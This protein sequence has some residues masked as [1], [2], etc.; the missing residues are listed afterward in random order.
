MSTPNV[1]VVPLQGGVDQVTTPILVQPGKLLSSSNY[2]PDIFGGYARMRGIER[3]DGRQSPT[4]AP[5]YVLLGTLTET[6]NVGD[7]VTGNTS[8]ATGKVIYLDTASTPD[9]IVVTRVTGTFVA[10]DLLNG[11]TVGS[12]TSAVYQ[13][14]TTTEEHSLY[15]KLTAAEYRPDIQTVPGE[16]AVLGVWEYKNDIYAFRNNVGSTQ[17]RMY[18]ATVSGWSQI[19]FGKELQFDAA[20]GEI[21]EGQ[22]VTGLSSGATGVVQRA[23]L[24]TGTWTSAGVGTLF[25]DTIT[26]AFTDNEAVQVGGVT[27][28][29]ANGDS[30]SVTLA[31]SGKFDFDN[32][33]FFAS[34]DKLR[35]YFADGQNYCHEFDGTRIIP[36]RTGLVDDKP[37]YVKGHRNHLFLGIQSSLQYSGIGSPYSWTAL[38]GAAELG[39]G[40]NITGV[41]PQRGD[42]TTG[43]LLA[44]TENKTYILYGTSSADFKLVLYSD[45]N[46]AYPYTVQNIAHAYFLDSKG[47]TQLMASQN[48]GDFQA[49][50]MSQAVQPTMD[51]KRNLAVASCT[52]RSK[53]QYRV[54]YSDGT[55]M[56]MQIMPTDGGN[57]VAGG[58]MP[59][60]YSVVTYMNTVVSYVANDGQERIFAG[61]DNG[62]VYELDKGTSLDGSDIDAHILMTFNYMKSP[63]IR[64]RY[65]R[66]VVQFRASGTVDVDIGYDL[67]Y[68]RMEHGI[69][70]SVNVVGGGFWDAFT[71]DNFTWDAAYLQ[72]FNIDTPGVGE[73]IS[74]LIKGNS[75]QD[76]AFTIHT[77]I[78]NYSIGRMQR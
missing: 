48:F 18:K 17:C 21:S 64:K 58:L 67:A 7:T 44:T 78:T 74:L 39:L 73:N 69:P 72:E 6:L 57:I 11:I 1:D 4:D 45:S 52:V 34:A 60:D 10:E 15:K 31:P 56:I 3:F 2:E 29:T 37:K 26:G 19:T 42:A 32:Y 62:Y 14:A 9:I 23:L 24:R 12:I 55:G 63:Y 77:V 38:T 50:I 75:N 30:T 8:G 16:G 49:G 35:M 76:D 27:K 13:G 43:S 65:R 36:I 51:A 28:V 47:I 66:V 5:Y 22:T 70:N 53:N 59:F 46:G 41:K 61:G 68:G 71:W 33:N 40:D 54:F 25:F 20:V